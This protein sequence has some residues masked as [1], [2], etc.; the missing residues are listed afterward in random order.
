MQKGGYTGP[1]LVPFRYSA[2]DHSGYAGTQ[3]NVVKDGVATPTGPVYTTDDG[4]APLTEYTEQQPA[5]PAD[6][7]PE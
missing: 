2:T 4:S 3:I 5:A 7:L 1:G 6:G